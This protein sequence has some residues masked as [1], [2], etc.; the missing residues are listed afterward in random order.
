M[1]GFTAMYQPTPNPSKEGNVL[2]QWQTANEVN[3]SHFNIQRS[4]NNKEFITIGKVSANNKSYNNYK[5]ID[6]QFPSLEGLGVGYYRIESVDNDG[7]KQYSTIQ[8][9]NFQHPTSNIVVFPNPAKEQVTITCKDAKELLIIDYLGKEV[10]SKKII[11]NQAS[12][13]NV[14]RF[15]KG[16][17]VVKVIM[18]NGD[19]KTEKLVVE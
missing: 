9:I 4:I 14:Q 6:V 17:Y 1:L 8:H 11:N 15:P 19:I 5:F 12:I 10:Y 2:L 7:R 13:I 3:V 16:V 18:T